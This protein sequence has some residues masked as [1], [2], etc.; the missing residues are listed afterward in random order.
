LDAERYK[1]KRCGQF[2]TL[3]FVRGP[4]RAAVTFVGLVALYIVGF[5]A[6]ADVGLRVAVMFAGAVLIALPLVTLLRYRC[7][8]CEPEWN[9]KLWGKL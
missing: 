2:K 1:C 5:V 6:I 4:I 8:S 9:R 7:L 3:F